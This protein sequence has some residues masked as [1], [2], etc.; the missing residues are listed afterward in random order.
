[1]R[2]TKVLIFVLFLAVFGLFFS[3]LNVKATVATSELISVKGAQVRLTGDNGIKFVGTVSDEY[4]ANVTEYGIAHLFGKSIKQRAK[5]LI[6]IAHPK[7]REQ[8][9]KDFYEY[10]KSA[11]QIY[12]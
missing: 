2:K 7:F 3:G 5:M 4:T 1:M 6:D 11:G 9:E 10:C 8:L 12:Y